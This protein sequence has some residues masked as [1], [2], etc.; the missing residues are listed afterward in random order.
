[1]MFLF[2]VTLLGLAVWVG[3][4][5]G[6][7]NGNTFIAKAINYF[8]LGSRRTINPRIEDK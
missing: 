6:I 8:N 1:M 7:S 4:K 2:E 3:Y 5:I